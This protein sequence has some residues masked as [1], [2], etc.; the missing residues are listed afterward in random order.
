MGEWSGLPIDGR[1]ATPSDAD[2]DE[3]RR[4]WNLAADQQPSAVVFVESADGRAT[5]DTSN[6]AERP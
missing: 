6:F 4:A 3:S 2:W 5:A 1:V